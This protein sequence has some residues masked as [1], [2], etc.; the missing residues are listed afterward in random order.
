M[1][2]F[3]TESNLCRCDITTALDKFLYGKS[4]LYYV[5]IPF[6]DIKDKNKKHLA[7]RRPGRTI[8]EIHID[9]ESN[10]IVEVNIYSHGMSSFENNV[11]DI[12]EEFNGKTLNREEL[13]VIGHNAVTTNEL[14]NA[15]DEAI[16]IR[17]SEY[18]KGD[19]NL[20]IGVLGHLL[21]DE[22]SD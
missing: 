15:Y 4:E 5:Y 6:D 14:Q 1:K 10:K 21:S 7:L 20:I 18:T 22:L 8:G 16:R 9:P 13:F 17:D 11:E 12:L 2:V 19:I 3:I